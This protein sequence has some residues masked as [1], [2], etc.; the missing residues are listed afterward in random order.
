VSVIAEIN[1]MFSEAS[2]AELTDKAITKSTAGVLGGR[3][4][5]GVKMPH[6]PEHREAINLALKRLATERRAAGV[7]RAG[8]PRS[9][10]AK[11]KMS[12][13]HRGKILSPETKAKL[14]AALRGKTHSP[15]AKA[16][17]GAA[18]RGKPLAPE[19]KA[20]LAA[21]LRG[22]TVSPETKAKIRASW[23]ARRAAKALGSK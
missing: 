22:R 17:I 19:T 8:S 10:E 18:F 9:P 20:K 3:A 12:A 7:Q 23:V 6:T 13:A 5:L 16:K 2:A 15:E 21:A 11:A 1:A 14:A 4:K